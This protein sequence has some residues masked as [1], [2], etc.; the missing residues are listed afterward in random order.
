MAK[1]FDDLTTEKFRVKMR[2]AAIAIYQHIFPGC[3]M[4]DLREHGVKVHVLDKEFGIDTLATMPS[5]QWLSVQEKYRRYECLVNPRYQV[6]PP[7]PDFTQEFKNACG[8][9]HESDGEWFK[10][11]AQLYFYGWANRLETDFAKWVMLDI[12][13]YKLIVEAAGGLGKLGKLMRNS[14][15][16]RASFYAIPVTRLQ[17]AFI[18]THKL[19]LL[20]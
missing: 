15:H 10:L 20:C 6:Q 19:G 17:G 16:G 8:T 7:I 18:A 9:I 2:P 13:K 14:Q 11:G 4:Q 1:A 3:E 12:A 5:G